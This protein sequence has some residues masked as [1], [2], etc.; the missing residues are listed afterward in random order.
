MAN[1]PKS[2]MVVVRYPSLKRDLFKRR[3]SLRPDEAYLETVISRTGHH[4]DCFL[5]SENDVGT[6][7]RE[8]DTREE[9]VA[10]L[11]QETLH[12]LFGGETCASHNFNDSERTLKELALLHATYLNKEYH[13]EVLKKWQTQNCY[14]EVSRRLGARFALKS[15][16]IKDKTVTFTLE[17]LG[18]AALYNTRPAFL[19]LDQGETIKKIPLS[20]D[21]RLWKPAQ[22]IKITQDLD[23]SKVKRLGLWLPDQAK[24]LRKDPRYALRLANQKT[25]DEKTGI[26]W[27]FEKT[28]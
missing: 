22:P 27:I 28:K 17:N 6:Y 25:W 15:G 3:D 19:V 21:P 4:N 14:Q 11:A 16:S 24:S 8:D 1:T 20:S 9:E 2:R 23:L 10:Y 12:T 5:S 13:P 26:N 18:F 7:G